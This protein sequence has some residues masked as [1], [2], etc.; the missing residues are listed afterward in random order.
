[1]TIR[2][3]NGQMYPNMLYYHPWN[4]NLNPVH[5]KASHFRVTG[6]SGSEHW[7]A[8][9]WTWAMSNTT[10]NVPPYAVLVPLSPKFQSVL[11]YGQPFLSYRPYWGN[12]TVWLPNSL[13]HKRSKIRHICLTSTH[14]SKITINL[15]LLPVVL[16]LQ[17]ILRQANRMASKWTSRL[18]GQR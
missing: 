1:M 13:E 9:N 5:F 18:T 2:A 10:S 4:P 3:V 11:L 8:S 15:P 6:H 7:M 12:F 17:A 16:E 14:E